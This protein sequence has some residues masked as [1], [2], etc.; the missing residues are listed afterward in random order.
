MA[1]EAIAK[2]DAPFAIERE[3]NGLPVHERK[4]VRNARSRSLVNELHDFLRER[5]T[6]LSG[7]SETSKAIDYSLKR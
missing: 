7:K 3:I 1:A 5:R 4:A 6:K 2:I